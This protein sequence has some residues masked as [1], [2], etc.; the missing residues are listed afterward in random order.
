[1]RLRDAVTEKSSYLNIHRVS[2][3]L[4]AYCCQYVS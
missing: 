4:S 3:V 1:M 2:K